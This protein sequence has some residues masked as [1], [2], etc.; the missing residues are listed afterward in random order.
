M[1]LKHDPRRIK[2]LFREHKPIYE[3][4][5]KRYPEFDF[6]CKYGLVR[7]RI[8]KQLSYRIGYVLTRA[9]IYNFYLIPF[10][11]ILEFIKFKMEKNK[12]KLPKL[13]EYPDFNDVNRV[14]NHLS[15]LIG[16]AL[17]KSIKQWYLGKPLILPFAWYAIYKKKENKEVRL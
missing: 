17:I 6:F 1:E 13:D 8:Q 12:K 5:H 15:Y 3:C 11:L 4:N 7:Y 10:R 9:K 2:E 14:K 16:E